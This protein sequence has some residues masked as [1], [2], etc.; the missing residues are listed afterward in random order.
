[1]HASPYLHLAAMPRAQPQ[2]R[3]S[4]AKVKS[5]SRNRLQICPP[6]RLLPLALTCGLL[7]TAYGVA[8][9]WV[10]G[11]QE[12]SHTPAMRAFMRS[13]MWVVVCAMGLTILVTTTRSIM[14]NT[15]G[16]PGYREM[17]AGGSRGGGGGGG[18]GGGAPRRGG[19]RAPVVLGLVGISF[20]LLGV[21]TTLLKA[22][23]RG[24]QQQQQQQQLL[25]SSSSS[26]SLLLD[27]LPSGAA[28]VAVGAVG[29]LP[30]LSCCNLWKL[31][32]RCAQ[33]HF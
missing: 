26:I 29:A 7:A 6:S 31:Y 17:M 24:R 8:R 20:V 1:M 9:W 11:E 18:G 2:L 4:V 22:W 10:D 30:V 33:I 15:G 13:W 27:V 23:R 25:P 19:S 28:L 14:K 16:K 12:P 5:H 3:V 21:A 32:S